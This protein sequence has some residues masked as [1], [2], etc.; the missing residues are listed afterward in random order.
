MSNPCQNGG[1]CKAVG[2]AFHCACPTGLRGLI[3]DVDV[4]ECDQ[5]N[6]GNRG[7]CVNTFGSFYC[8]C[9][10]GYEDQLCND[11]VPEDDTQVEF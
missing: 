6:C 5:E 8:N 9:S 3:C 10:D 7:E 4:N 1:E 11:Q 2:N